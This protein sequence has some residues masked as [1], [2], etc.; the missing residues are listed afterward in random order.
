MDPARSIVV[1][2]RPVHV[3]IAGRARRRHVLVV[4]LVRLGFVI[5]APD[6]RVGDRCPE[7]QSNCSRDP[8]DHDSAIN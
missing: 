1:F 3:A 2:V 7:T 5:L 6:T 4:I 8:E